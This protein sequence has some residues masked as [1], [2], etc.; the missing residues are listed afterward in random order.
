M[1]HRAVIH[2]IR[3]QRGDA[4][5]NAELM[6]MSSV[7]V[8][9]TVVNQ[10]I[11]RGEDRSACEISIIGNEY[12]TPAIFL[13]AREDPVV[14]VLLGRNLRNPVGSPI[15]GCNGNIGSGARR[16]LDF[17]GSEWLLGGCWR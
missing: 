16:P 2:R 10:P 8:V 17:K 15:D 6:V 12:H 9:V 14:A 5:R 1:D 3:S 11:T 7:V 13:G 4:G